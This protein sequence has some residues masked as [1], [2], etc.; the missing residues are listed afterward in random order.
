VYRVKLK[1]NRITVQCNLLGNGRIKFISAIYDT[2]AKYSCFCASNV[3]SAIKENNMLNKETKIISGFVGGEAAK[4]Y[5]IPVDR[6]AVGNI[7][8]GQQHIWIT[9]DENVTTNV[10]GYDIISQ[11]ARTSLLKS[12][13]ECFFSTNEELFQYVVEKVK[14]G[15]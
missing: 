14:R 9:F 8:L 4:F 10:I 15:A 11:V 2:G 12:G 3:Y 1:D 7:D 13:E 6:L 5:R